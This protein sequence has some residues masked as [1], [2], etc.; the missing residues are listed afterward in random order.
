M[1]SVFSPKK[2]T[3]YKYDV[4][5]LQAP[6]YGQRRGYKAVYRLNILAMSHHEVLEST[7][8]KFNV[9]DLV[10]ADY[11]ARYIGTGDI[12]LIDEGINGKTYYQLNIGGWTKINRVRV[13]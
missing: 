7:F 12:I 1:L 9:L 13:I 3:Q 11:D 6:S 4:T 10:P 2:P 5:I 8:R